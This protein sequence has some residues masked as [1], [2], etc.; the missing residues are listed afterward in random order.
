MNSTKRDVV[1]LY[2]SKDYDQFVRP[3]VKELDERGITYWLD[4]AEISL[5]VAVHGLE[6]TSVQ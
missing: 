3:L 1:L 5:G 4:K 6:V 2:A